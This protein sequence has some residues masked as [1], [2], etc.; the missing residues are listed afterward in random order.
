MTKPAAAVGEGLVIGLPLPGKKAPEEPA[1]SADGRT[2]TYSIHFDEA[3]TVTSVP[4]MKDVTYEAGTYTYTVDLSTVR[5]PEQPA[6][7]AGT[8]QDAYEA[9]VDALTKGSESMP[10]AVLDRLE[11]DLC[12]VLSLRTDGLPRGSAYS[13]RLVYKA[14]S[15]K[16]AGETVEL[17]LTVC[18]GMGIVARADNLSLSADGK[19]LTYTC[20]VPRTVLSDPGDPASEVIRAAGTYTYTVDLTT[21]EAAEAFQAAPEPA[22]EE[23]QAAYDA[24][25]AQRTQGVTV[26][27]RL[28]SDYCTV[29]YT[30]ASDAKGERPSLILVFKPGS[31][32]GAGETVSVGLP[33]IT[34]TIQAAPEDLALSADGKTLT[35]TC[36]VDERSTGQQ[37][38]TYHYAITLETGEIRFEVADR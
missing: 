38:G 26:L 7:G 9:A 1:L 28:E 3:T 5:P 18:D 36:V 15:A 22:T 33:S 11:S 37:A 35:F 24:A 23:E 4:D 30:S 21:G 10:V 25:I 12:T 6:T 29:L 19:T 32:K 13:L 14:G 34:D 2:F 31:A 17:P 27:E 20:I 8:G 16:G